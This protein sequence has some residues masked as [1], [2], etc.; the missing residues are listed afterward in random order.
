MN[1]QFP[2]NFWWG[3]RGFGASDRGTESL[4][5]EIPDHLGSLVFP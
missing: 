1:Y 2:E 5:W 4:P 3:K